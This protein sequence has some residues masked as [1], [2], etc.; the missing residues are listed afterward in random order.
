MIRSGGEG[1]LFLGSRSRGHSGVALTATRTTQYLSVP[2]DDNLLDLVYEPRE[3]C[4][5]FNEFC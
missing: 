3:V 4:S 5:E 1:V 2:V